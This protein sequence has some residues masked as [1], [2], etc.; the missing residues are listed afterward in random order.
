MAL[1]ATL[2][3]RKF[4]L[5]ERLSASIVVRLRR[6]KPLPQEKNQLPWKKVVGFVPYAA[7]GFQP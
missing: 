1:G 6:R 3:A 7:A 5:W 2:S 4:S